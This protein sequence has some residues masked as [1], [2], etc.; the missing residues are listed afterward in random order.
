MCIRGAG[1]IIHTYVYQYTCII[2]I[3]YVVNFIY[4]RLFQRSRVVFKKLLVVFFLPFFSPFSLLWG[5][6]SM[7]QN[8]KPRIRDGTGQHK[9]PSPVHR[10]PASA[11]L[12]PY[13]FVLQDDG[14]SPS[15][16][17]FL[18]FR[19]SGGWQVWWK[20]CNRHA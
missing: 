19:C 10:V 3:I 12:V 6:G 20:T 2:N 13:N 1:L 11:M 9:N 18:F 5:N 14:S 8:E 7:W 4:S 16:K 15:H 17:G